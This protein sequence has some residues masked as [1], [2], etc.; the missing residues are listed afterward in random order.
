MKYLKILGLVAIAAAA[1]MAFASAGTASA[2]E[3]TCTNA[4]HIEVMCSVGT[5]IHAVNEGRI[6]WHPPFGA[7]E[8]SESTIE[9]ST[10]NTGGG[11]ETIKVSISTISWGSCNATIT[12]LRK[13]SLEIHTKGTSATEGTVT[14]TGTEVTTEFIGTHCIYNTNGTDIGT[15]TGSTA[16]TIN[17]RTA[18]ID[19]EATIP[20]TGGRSG[21]FCGSTAQWTGAYEIDKPD[22]LGVH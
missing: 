4:E 20:R 19:L 7:I 5:V 11:T 18:T 15:L 6:I 9:G 16:P 17:G 13:G 3:L 21:A 8:C 10:T 14:S 22:W 2:T 1:L 12:V